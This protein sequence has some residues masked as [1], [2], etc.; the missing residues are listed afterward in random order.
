[1]L[2]P[3]GATGGKKDAW[4]ERD[5]WYEPP[6]ELLRRH[7]SRIGDLP[8]LAP[9]GEDPRPALID[10]MLEACAGAR[11]VLV[12]YEPFEKA[13]IVELADC[14][15]DRADALMD[16]HGRIVD[17][18]PIVRNH[19]YDRDF[20][21]SFSLKKVLP[22]LDDRTR[23]GMLS[24]AIIESVSKP[25]LIEDSHVSIG[26]SIG[27]TRGTVIG[28]NYVRTAGTSNNAG[29]AAASL[30]AAVTAAEHGIAAVAKWRKPEGMSDQE[31]ARLKVQVLAIFNGVMGNAALQAKDY[32]NARRY[33][34]GA[35]SVDP[36][37]FQDIY[38]LSVAQLESTPV[39]PLRLRR[40]SAVSTSSKSR[41]WHPRE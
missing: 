2:T 10:G 1:M 35:V 32:A 11:T 18:L 30:A 29:A 39:D 20:R 22:A 9:R 34:I 24:T 28:N 15:P 37:N 3:H 4:D 19:V 41:R 26:V 38:Q 14:F 23:I 6:A 16:L 40:K 33:F 8:V 17:L 7:V 13:R 5:F 36:D 31:F 21:G 25:Y 12:Y 27:N